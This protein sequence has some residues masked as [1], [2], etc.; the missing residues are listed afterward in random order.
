MKSVP[1]PD[2]KNQGM[3]VTEGLL[4]AI[5][6]KYNSHQYEDVKVLIHQRRAFGIEKYGQTLRS[7]DGRNG[8][9]DAR[10]E[11]GDLL[12]YV[13]KVFGKDMTE[14]HTVQELKD[15]KLLWKRSKHLIDDIIE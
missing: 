13:Y 5:N 7:D 15:F 2:P 4:E 8:L 3:D 9:E 10:Q 1:E 12:Q 14:K 11:L 6:S